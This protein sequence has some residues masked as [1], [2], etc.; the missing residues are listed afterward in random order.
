MS[1]CSY[2]HIYTSNGLTLHDIAMSLASGQSLTTGD[3]DDM[4]AM[5]G[6]G[7]DLILCDRCPRSFHGGGY[8]ASDFLY[9]FMLGFN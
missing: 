3:S 6:D 5:C 9:R 4:C 1:C 2:R 8:L 7:G